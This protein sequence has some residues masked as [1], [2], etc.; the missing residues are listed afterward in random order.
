MIQN[1]KQ[2]CRKK[3]VKN[4]GVRDKSDTSFDKKAKARYNNRKM[5]LMNSNDS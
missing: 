2:K 1:T 4:A 3:A 5:E